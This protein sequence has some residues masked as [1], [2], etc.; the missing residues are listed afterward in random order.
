V[1]ILDAIRN[2]ERKLEKQLGKVQRELDGIRMAAKALGHSSN[3]E[4]K[5]IKNARTFGRRQSKDCSGCEKAM[6]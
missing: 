4:V 5:T 1:T 6:G 3:E 2:E